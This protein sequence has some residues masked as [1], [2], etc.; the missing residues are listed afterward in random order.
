MRRLM[1][2]YTFT[3]R[4]IPLQAKGIA[5][6][7]GK[8]AAVQKAREEGRRSTGLP[9]GY[10]GGLNPYEARQLGLPIRFGGKVYTVSS[11]LPFTDLNDVAAVTQGNGGRPTRSSRASGRCSRRFSSSRRS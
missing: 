10:E 6:H 11:A 7:P 5:K 2:F 1:P 9:E 8:Y 3:S 4:N